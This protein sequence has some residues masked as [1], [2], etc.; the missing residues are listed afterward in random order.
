VHFGQKALRLP[1]KAVPE[2][3]VRLV[4]AYRDERQVGEDFRTHLERT[5]GATGAAEMLADLAEFPDPGTHPEYYVDYDE[6]GPYEAAVGD[7]ECAV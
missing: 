4:A 1:A 2:A 5:G 7:S 6:T 3:V